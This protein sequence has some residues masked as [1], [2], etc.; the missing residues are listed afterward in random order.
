MIARRIRGIAFLL[1]AGVMPVAMA[2]EDAKVLRLALPDIAYLD[3]QQITDLSSSRVA[4]V[5]FEGLYQFDYL[6]TPARVVPNTAAAM[7]EISADG[8]TGRSGSNPESSSRAL[9]RSR[10]SRASSSPRTTCIRSRACSTPI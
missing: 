2:A 8:R 7:P 9:R 3:P 4:N 10:A 1:F 5:I 6:A